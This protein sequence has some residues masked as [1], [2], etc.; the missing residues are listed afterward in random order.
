M[1]RRF[2][3][4]GGT[5]R[6][7]WRPSTW[8]AVLVAAVMIVAALVIERFVPPLDGAMRVADGDSFELGGTRVRLEGIDAPELHQNCGAPGASWPCGQRAK[9][10]MQQAVAEAGKDGVTCRP[11]DGDRY[12]RSV[13]ICQAGGRDLGAL[14]V[15]Q[16]WAVATS[17]AYR[18]E[19]AA[20]RAA[21]RGIW[22]GP[23][24]MPADFRARQR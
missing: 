24:E 3:A 19:E 17:F 4:A 10:A 21:G 11:V 23:F 14:M 7:R 1:P 15:E 18:G 9:Q 2:P 6:G 16:G 20:A 22:S 5:R 13:S 8:H 12:G